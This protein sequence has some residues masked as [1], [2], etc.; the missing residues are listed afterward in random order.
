MTVII[1][2]QDHKPQITERGKERGSWLGSM[3]DIDTQPALDAM[4]NSNWVEF[5]VY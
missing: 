4:S 2:G 1:I 5:L 3:P